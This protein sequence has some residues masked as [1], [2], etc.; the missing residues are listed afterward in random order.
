MRDTACVDRGSHN[1]GGELQSRW[2]TRP[3]GAAGGVERT[4]SREHVLRGQCRAQRFHNATHVAHGAT[5]LKEA[6]LEDAVDGVHKLLACGCVEKGDQVI[7]F[8]LIPQCGVPGAGGG[9][10]GGGCVATVDTEA[11]PSWWK[12]ALFQRQVAV[13]AHKWPPGCLVCG[14][15][16]HQCL[17]DGCHHCCRAGSIT[18][19]SH[20][21]MCHP[22][23]DEQDEETTRGARHGA[24]HGAI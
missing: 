9:V 19:I 15:D 22:N 18:I 21:C 20:P 5:A 16:I 8:V 11:G 17:V 2:P 14:Q 10:D 12:H 1:F 3:L 4:T 23:S 13:H 6:V 7:V 24:T